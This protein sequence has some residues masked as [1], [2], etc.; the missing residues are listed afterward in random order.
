MPRLATFL[1]LNETLQFEDPFSL[2]PLY[3]PV[4]LSNLYSTNSMLFSKNFLN[5]FQKMCR[6]SDHLNIISLSINQNDQIIPCFNT[7]N[8]LSDLK[9]KIPYFNGG[10]WFLLITLTDFFSQTI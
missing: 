6:S 3:C 2:A 10:K 7:E 8:K 4:K 5:I 1:N 9:A